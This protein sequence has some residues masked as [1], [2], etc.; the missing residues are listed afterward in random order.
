MG[1]PVIGSVSYQQGSDGSLTFTLHVNFAQPN[2]LYGIAFTCG[3]SHDL[4]CGFTT[5]DQFTTNGKGKADKEVTLTLDFLRAPP[6]GC[7]YR[8]DHIDAVGPLFNVLT[9]GAINY[10]VPCAPGGSPTTPTGHGD[11]TR[12]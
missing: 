12:R 2:G 1:G 5:V 9:A 6:F 7:G 4:A 11:L 10:F 8:T 3:P